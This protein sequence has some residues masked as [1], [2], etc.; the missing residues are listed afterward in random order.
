MQRAGKR[1]ERDERMRKK[2]G[3]KLVRDE[4]KG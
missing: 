2:E 4:Q 1:R 3:D